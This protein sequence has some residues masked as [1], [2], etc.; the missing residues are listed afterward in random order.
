MTDVHL[1]W[2]WL[3]G[4]QFLLQHDRLDSYFHRNH[5]L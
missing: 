5:W 2:W 1:G 4:L 3:Y